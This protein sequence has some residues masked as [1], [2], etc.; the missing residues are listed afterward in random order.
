MAILVSL[1]PVVLTDNKHH[2]MNSV[3]YNREYDMIS[4]QFACHV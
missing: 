1:F 3:G 4:T 2:N